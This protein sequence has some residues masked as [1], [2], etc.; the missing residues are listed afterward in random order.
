MAESESL[1]RGTIRNASQNYETQTKIT[2]FYSRNWCPN[3]WI[4][5]SHHSHCTSTAFLTFYLSASFLMDLQVDSSG[6]MA[7]TISTTCSLHSYLQTTSNCSSRVTVFVC[8]LSPIPL[9][10]TA[11]MST[12]N[13]HFEVMDCTKLRR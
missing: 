6:P 12:H 9:L 5:T 1:K 10:A 7:L 3:L 4:L 11:S 8:F 2:I 13:C